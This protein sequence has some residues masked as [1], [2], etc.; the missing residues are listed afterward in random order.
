M[1]EDKQEQLPEFD[2]VTDF[3]LPF[4]EVEEKHSSPILKGLRDNNIDA[5]EFLGEEKVEGVGLVEAMDEKQVEN[6][7]TNFGQSFLDFV[8]DIPQ[9][10]GTSTL[11]AGANITNNLIQL[12]GF[13]TN[14]AFKDTQKGNHISDYVTEFSQGYNKGTE[15]F[16]AKLDQYRQDNDVNGVANFV[17]DMGIDLAATI[18][19]D[20]MLKKVG[21][22]SYASLP[23]AFGLSYAFTGG[24]KKLEKNI[25]V[26]SEV[27]NRLNETL[28]ALPNTPE[29]EVA[30][31]VGNAFEG[32]VWAGVGDRLV[33][34]FKLLKNNVPA[35][36]NQQTAVSVGGA[37]ASGEAVN[38]IN[39]ATDQNLNV[40]EPTQNIDEE[41]KTLNQSS[42]LQDTD[43][44][45]A[46]GGFGP[47]FFS[48]VREA[49]KK[50]PNKGS[51]QQ[52]FNTIKNTKGVKETELKWTGLD[53]FLKD[54]KSVTKQEI[55]D[56]LK[57]NTLEVAEVKY[58]GPSIQLSDDLAK[59]KNTFEQ[60][61]LNE[62]RKEGLGDFIDS[63]NFRKREYLDN[64]KYDEIEVFEPELELFYKFPFNTFKA[65]FDDTYN[66][67]NKTIRY[68]NKT[69]K[70]SDLDF[71][72]FN[73]EK[74]I[75][76]YKSQTKA[77]RFN[78]PSY[79]EPG[80]DDYTEL[81]F[82]LQ[83]NKFNNRF[84]PVEARMPNS[85][86]VE[87]QSYIGK[88]AIDYTSPRVHFGTK[89]EFAHVRF[90]TRDLNG[91][92]ILTVEE[93]QS[94]LAQ[95]VASGS[96]K[97]KAMYDITDFPFKNNWY[98]LTTKRLIRYAAD[99]GFDAVAIPKGSVS[100]KRYGQEIDKVNNLKII[101]ERKPKDTMYMDP[102]SGGAT[103]D[104]G[105]DN[106]TFFVQGAKDKAPVF[107]TS[108]ENDEVYKI[109]KQYKAPN[110][111]KSTVDEVL[112]GK[113][114][115]NETN[116][117]ITA[118]YKIPE[119]VIGSGKGKVQL[120]DKAIPSFMKKYGKKWNAKVYDDNLRTKEG[121]E[122]QSEYISGKYQGPNMPV[123]IIQITDDMRKSVQQDGQ[124]LF[125]ILGLG[126]GSKIASDSMQNNIISETTN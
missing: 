43:N 77:P 82:K 17:S 122:K 73:L 63:K 10:A 111:L 7:K 112:T 54:K 5:H 70:L 16:I 40:E 13:G 92:K 67:A 76:A 98:E 9:A 62:K 24:D 99:N 42:S 48:M 58:G 126:V 74:D 21:I 125:S 107:S 23:L 57:N 69:Y 106:F 72:K 14:I 12:F 59:R 30:E 90:K 35:Y 89:N 114:K 52:L 97:T 3:Y 101:V 71:E 120:Y 108:V 96:V 53:D 4:K 95:G 61:Y 109:L 2:V 36:M 39:Q 78:Q 118:D 85:L 22:P 119:M 64:I 6:E 41:K 86:G 20:K 87:P 45:Y 49:A 100:A 38:K 88:T 29:A 66:A 55:Q 44:M 79:V 83:N 33:K 80:G 32:T 60:N 28:G 37:A 1:S 51:G 115:F 117:L 91:Q 31:L 11:E 50:I 121:L 105:K 116:E 75:R 102:K 25:M 103:L 81:V 124:A 27:I 8:K 110:E 113:Y 65:I 123:T 84:Y 93:M 104:K 94:D 46:S 26:D 19:M 18:P 56:Y 68:E 34:V 47:V 15:E